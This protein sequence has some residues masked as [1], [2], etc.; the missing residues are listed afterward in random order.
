[1]KEWGY[2]PNDVPDRWLRL[3]AVAV[4]ICVLAAYAL[5]FHYLAG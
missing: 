4:T 5:C 2:D 3:E 1:M